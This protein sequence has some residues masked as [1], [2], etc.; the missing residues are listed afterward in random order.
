MNFEEH[1]APAGDK[2]I[3]KNNYYSEKISHILVPSL[4]HEIDRGP[5]V[6]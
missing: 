5:K 4:D 1:Y 6:D 2:L 3:T